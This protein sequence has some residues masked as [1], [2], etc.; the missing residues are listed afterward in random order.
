ML[1]QNNIKQ[2]AFLRRILG[3]YIPLKHARNSDASFTVSGDINFKRKLFGGQLF[4]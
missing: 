4:W 3:M 1:K 2:H